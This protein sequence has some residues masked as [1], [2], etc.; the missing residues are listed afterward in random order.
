MSG[1]NKKSELHIELI[2]KTCFYSNVRTLLPNKYWDILRKESYEKAGHRCE[3]CRDTGK[4]Q[5]YRHDVECH[6]IWDYNDKTRVQKLL[7]LISLCPKCHQVKHFGRTSAIGKQ[8]EAFEHLE[9]VNNWNH[10][11]CAKHAGDSM[12]EWMDRSKYKWKLDLGILNE[13]FDIPKKLITEA[14]KKRLLS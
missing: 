4:N 13:K 8:A 12:L 5:G 2:P 10:K 7:G 6:E 1:K 3:I 11:Q 9:K 14:E